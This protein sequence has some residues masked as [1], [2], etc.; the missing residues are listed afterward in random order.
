MGKS[1]EKGYV[2]H[3]FHHG[4][5]RIMGEIISY[6]YIYINLDESYRPHRN[7]TGMMYVSEPRLITRGYS[8]SNGN[9]W[10]ITTWD[11]WDIIHV[12]YWLL[13]ED[14]SMGYNYLIYN[15]PLHFLVHLRMGKQRGINVFCTFFFEVF[16]DSSMFF[17]RKSSINGDEMKVLLRYRGFFLSV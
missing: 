13:P 6:I 16:W 4:K 9:I 2:F 5:S 11:I 15:S 14:I 3:M 10:D 17:F 12:I 7:I 8:S 1:C